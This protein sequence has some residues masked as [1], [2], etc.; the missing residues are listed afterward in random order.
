MKVKESAAAAQTGEVHSGEPL[1]C[2]V[3]QVKSSR[4]LGKAL[5]KKCVQLVFG[6]CARMHDD[7]K[8]LQRLQVDVFVMM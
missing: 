5:F 1:F 3:D 7:M 4:R 2:S 6:R 8:A